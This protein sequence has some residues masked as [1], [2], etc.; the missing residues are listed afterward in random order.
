MCANCRAGLEHICE[1]LN[2]LGID[3]P[4]AFQ[5]TWNVPAHTVYP[6]PESLPLELGALIE[7]LAVACHDARLA[8][9]QPGQ[10]TVVIGGGPIGAL[11]ALVARDAGAEVTVAELNPHRLQRLRDLGFEAL[12]PREKDLVKLLKERTDGA[13]ADAV[14]EVSGHP[15][16]AKL[17]TELPRARG[18]IVIVGIFAQPVEF[19]LFPFFWKE[20]RMRG[21]RVYERQDFQRAINLASA[22]TLPLK[23]LITET[24]PLANLKDG[25]E[26]MTAGGDTLKIL[27]N[28]QE[29]NA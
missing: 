7:P 4:G 16:G 15:D 21:A 5:Q 9:I 14:F 19:P 6:L 23:D 20:L 26:Q 8:E 22:G 11:I 12:D 29:H 27:I 25:L 13:G 3:S 1:N 24:L 10:K 28:C 2:F 17:A 18:L